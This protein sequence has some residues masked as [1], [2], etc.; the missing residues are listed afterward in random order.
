MY[1]F[2]KPF[3][4]ILSLLFCVMIIDTPVSF[5]QSGSEVYRHI[6]S[7]DGLINSFVWEM[8]QDRNGFIWIAGNNG[9]DRYNGHNAITFRNDPNNEA[10]ITDGAVFSLY[11]DPDGYIWIGTATGLSIFNPSDE[12]FIQIKTPDSVPALRVVRGITPAADG[13]VWVGGTG[14]GL[15]RF[16]ADTPVNGTPDT[17]FY[18]FNESMENPPM[19]Q[20]I[21][22][23]AKGN[24]WIG[25]DQGLFLFDVESG[26][27]EKPGP[28]EEALERVLSR[29]VW[30]IF[31][32]S[33][34]SM[35]ITTELGLVVWHNGT[36]EPELITSLGNGAVDLTDAYMQSINE[37][38]EGILWFGT[39]EIGAYRYNPGTEEVKS[40]RHNEASLNSIIEDDVHYIFKDIDGNIWLGYH[41]VGITVMYTQPW[42]YQFISVTDTP[43]PTH[44]LNNIQRVV[45]DENGNLWLATR[46]GIV[47]IDSDTNEMVRY[48]H[49]PQ[50]M[51]DDNPVNQLVGFNFDG[52]RLLTY[53]H[54]NTMY[55]FPI[56]RE[57][58]IEIAIPDSI[59]FANMTTVSDNH[60]YF[61]T[62]QTGYLLQVDK[63][64]LGLNIIEP[65]RRLPDNSDNRAVEP[66][67]G[68]DG[69]MYVKY[70]YLDGGNFNW[71]FFLFDPDEES[72][73]KFELQ[74]P[75]GINIS[76]PSLLSSTENGVFWTVTNR[77]LLKEDLMNNESSFLFQNEAAIIAETSLGIMEDHE[78]YLWMGGINEIMKLDPVKEIL[79]ILEADPARKPDFFRKPTQLNNG[80]IIFPGVG[81]YVRF[82]SNHQQE[83]PTIQNI[84]V[85]ELRSG[86][87][88]YSTISA[89]GNYE[90]DHANSN[91]SLTYLAMNYRTPADTRYRYRLIGH[92]DEWT[93]VGIQRSVFLANLPP[94]NY[95]FQVQA[96]QRFGN[97]SDSTAELNIAILPPWWRTIPAYLFFALLFAGSVFMVDRA[98]RKRVISKEREITREKELAQAKEI[99]V[100]YENL[101]T[102]KEQLVQQEKLASLGQLTAGIA[103]EI[104]NPLNFVNN[105]SEVSDEMIDELKE[106]LRS[107][108]LDQANEIAT[109]IGSNL[110]T[111]HKHGIRADGIVKSM[112]Q[113][114]RGGSGKMEP[115]P[116][117][118]LIIEYVNLAF[119]GMRAGKEPI[120]MDI[121]LQLDDSIGEVPLIAEDFSRVI[122]N[123]CN[124]AFDAMRDKMTGDG[125]PKTGN[126]SPFE[127]G[128]G[129]DPSLSY[130]PKLTVRTKS[131]GNTITIEIEDNGPGIPDDIKDKILQPFF[132]TKKGTAGTGLGLSI[133]NDIIK[134]HGGSL[135]I[136]SS[137]GKTVFSI[138]LQNSL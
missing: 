13:S 80:D 78:G 68:P 83:N 15:Y 40:Y 110:K 75:A 5:A 103:H 25:S 115:T 55:T 23:S 18:P 12:R 70:S 2:L 74:A 31:K 21:E 24:I 53:S 28:F 11:E 26:R 17:V 9:L 107:G 113:H 64:S 136:D 135:E 79:T 29:P 129:D 77:G 86:A 66:Y 48:L 4:T 87:D 22:E 89:A 10:S 99:E 119:H 116:L 50:N 58:F 91:I 16:A 35:W 81:G 59:T 109:D 121:D 85:I 134:A 88:T 76:H 112:L 92:N 114:S 104:K 125:G 102:A 130:Q 124:N 111:I 98:Q 131:D 101:K 45:D 90:I 54:A 1:A 33:N 133:T 69:K 62:F 32:D 95:I 71:D 106:A 49:D 43:D 117:N 20:S 61:G 63:E 126:K 123:L 34:H 56:D 42:Q 84:H 52:D 8:I 41:N 82:D 19:F 7:R 118:P 128:Q 122:L 51:A 67:V 96:G 36:D 65:P 73:T 30:K 27:Y 100:A 14:G 3:P 132:T 138:S 6:T 137:E 38:D 57:Q 46:H 39:G 120:N 94:G 108:D 105:F 72:F 37:D 47:K 127:G 44:P 93:E 60:Y 97:Y